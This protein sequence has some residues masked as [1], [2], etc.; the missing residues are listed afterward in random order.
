MKW[1]LT[2]LCLSIYSAA[3]YAVSSTGNRLL[4]I[5]EDE[6]ERDLF[7]TFWADLE[8]RGYKLTFESPKNTKLSLYHL[9]ARA[10][11]HLILLPPKSKGLGP[12]LTPKAL[13]DF[14]NDNGNILVALSGGAPT[15]NGVSSLL[16][17]LDI[18]LSPDRAPIVVDHFNY[19]TISSA[20]KHNVLLLPRPDRLRPD[21]KPF[22]N[23][24]GILA[25][26]NVAGQ[27]LGNNSPLLA[28]IIRAPETAYSYDKRDDDQ[29]IDQKLPTGSQLALATAMQ[30]RNSARVTVL[31]SVDSLKDEW[32]NAK[33]QAPKGEKVE[34]ANKQF[35]Q[36]LTAWTFQETGVVKVTRVEH[37]LN[38]KG[39]IESGPKE[40]N[41][42]IYR[43]KN[44]V[45]FTIELSE[46]S[47]DQWIPYWTAEEDAIQL[48]FTMLSPFHRLNL[49]PVDRTEH[50]AIYRTSFTLP[51][52]HGIFSFRVNYKRPFITNIE[53]KHEVTVRHFAHD[54]WPRS[55]RI[56][57][58]WVWIAGLWSVIG[59]FLAFVMVW[60]YSAP[61][62]K[63]SDSKKEQ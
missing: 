28:P 38:E 59:G 15:P 29:S 50:A 52:Q 27:S 26:P 53:E 46:Y 63:S 56:S 4:V 17:E 11:D 44:D 54:E 21:T 1:L 60:L 32:F 14:V 13:L 25:L 40:L 45:T 19:D 42:S 35:A 55:W 12:S 9:G 8:S 6:T 23:G 37:H 10:Y 47:Y 33:V 20:E 31:G 39:D 16:L 34:T 51:D 41:P 30:A 57:G 36:Q 3:V 7:S 43:I 58:G 22:F 61:P 2:F 49:Q 62:M 5:Q 18:H 48:E 24:D